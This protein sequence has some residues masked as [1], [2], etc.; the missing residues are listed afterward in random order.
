MSADPAGKGPSKAG[1]SVRT[2]S[3]L[4][5]GGQGHRPEAPSVAVQANLAPLSVS[6][7]LPLACGCG[8]FHTA[9]LS[10]SD[11]LVGAGRGDAG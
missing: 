8:A 10:E 6:P 11:G 2:P 9:A 4:L 7:P 5:A 1:A 3:T